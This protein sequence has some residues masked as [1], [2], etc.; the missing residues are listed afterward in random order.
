MQEF[1]LV[2]QKERQSAPETP[3]FQSQ[4]AYAWHHFRDGLLRPE[5]DS[6]RVRFN[7]NYQSR[8]ERVGDGVNSLGIVLF[9][10]RQLSYPKGGILRF[11][12]APV[13]DKVHIETVFGDEVVA[14]ED[15]HVLETHLPWVHIW[16]KNLVFDF[17]KRAR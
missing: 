17:L 12:H 16:F 6:F 9:N 7:D 14:A 2:I 13:R 5:L 10:M 15:R 11:S 3:S 8:I 4:E 1:E